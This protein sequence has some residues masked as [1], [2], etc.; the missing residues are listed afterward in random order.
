VFGA[1]RGYQVAGLLAGIVSST[2]AT[3]TFARQSRAEPALARPLAIGAIGASAM[4]FPRVIVALLVLNVDVAVATLPYLLPPFVIGVLMLLFRRRTNPGSSEP[5]EMANPLQILP[6]LQM[7]V[8]FQVVF[9]AV[10]WAHRHFGSGGLLASGAI[11]GL[12]DV[13]ALTISMAKSAPIVTPHVAAQ[14]IAIG[15]LV[16]CVLKSVVALILGARPF[17][18]LAGLTVASMAAAIAA[19]F[20]V[21]IAR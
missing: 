12:T 21:S 7:A 4:L 9:I 17:G 3:I 5:G 19:A 8:T 6:A 15:I 20:A 14:A 16:N 13:D 11:V 10:E 2:S 18:K 1:D